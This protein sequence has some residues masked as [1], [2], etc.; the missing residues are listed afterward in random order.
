MNTNL[1]TAAPAIGEPQDSLNILRDVSHVY[2]SLK[3]IRKQ[4]AHLAKQDHTYQALADAMGTTKSAAHQ[5]LNR[6][7]A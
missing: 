2:E 6:T 1:D 3:A 4:A 5:L 7:A